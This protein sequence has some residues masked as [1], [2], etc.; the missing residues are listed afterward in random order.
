[1]IMQITSTSWSGY[2]EVEYNQLGYLVRSDTRNADLTEAQQKWF[3][4][5]MPRELSELQRTI[6]GSTAVITE[7]NRTVTFDDAWKMYHDEFG[8]KKKALAKWNKMPEAETL[9]AFDYI[10]KYQTKKP[11]GVAK[12]YFLTYL[13]AELWNN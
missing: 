12:M 10:K 1:M 4:N 8:S 11:D 9:K 6:A 3:L 13:N 7:I 5:R 2:I